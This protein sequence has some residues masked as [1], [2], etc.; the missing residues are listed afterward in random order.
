MVR[1]H[2]QGVERRLLHGVLGRGE[3]LAPAD[4][5]GEHARREGPDD[6]FDVARSPLG[7]LGQLITSRTSIHSYSGVPP[8]PGSD[9]T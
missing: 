4:Q 3:V 9:D 5:T 8:G 1:P 7:A 2:P 6:V